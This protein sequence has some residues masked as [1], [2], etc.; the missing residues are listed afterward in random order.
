MGTLPGAATTTAHGTTTRF[1]KAALS[2]VATSNAPLGAALP[3]PPPRPNV[4]AVS[5]Q[6]P[7]DVPFPPSM[8]TPLLLGLVPVALTAPPSGE[9]VGARNG[10]AVRDV[11]MTQEAVREVQTEAPEEALDVAAAAAQVSGT[12]GKAKVS[13]HGVPCGAHR[14]IVTFADLKGKQDRVATAAKTIAEADNPLPVSE[15]DATKTTND[16]THSKKEK[17]KEKGRLKKEH[18]KNRSVTQL[19]QHVSEGSFGEEHVL[20]KA[21]L[22]K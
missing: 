8:E 10:Q 3:P 13:S 18:E 16:A 6:H 5:W 12:G 9:G 15:D 17:K 7:A 20:T 1:G 22:A 21:A 4:Y 14:G 19:L 11:D 2:V